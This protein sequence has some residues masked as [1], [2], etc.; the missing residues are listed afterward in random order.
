M[1]KMIKITRSSGEATANIKFSRDFVRMLD[2]V[3]HESNK[4]NPGLPDATTE[5]II[6]MSV[7]DAINNIMIEIANIPVIMSNVLEGNETIH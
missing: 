2:R 7:S 4:C 3:C 1:I 6:S 5:D